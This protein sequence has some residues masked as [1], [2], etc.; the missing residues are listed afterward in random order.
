MLIAFTSMHLSSAARK[1]S[2]V[3]LQMNLSHLTSPDLTLSRLELRSCNDMLI[4]S[5]ELEMESLIGQL[6]TRPPDSRDRA[7]LAKSPRS[8]YR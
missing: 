5:E 4:V 8:N 1:I 3:K 7:Q 6:S 2:S